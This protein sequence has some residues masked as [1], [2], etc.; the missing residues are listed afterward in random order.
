MAETNPQIKFHSEVSVINAIAL[1]LAILTG[2]LTENRIRFIPVRNFT[3]GDVCHIRLFKLR[4]YGGLTISAF[5]SGPSSPGS[6]VGRG[7]CVVFLGET[8]KSH[9]ASLHPGV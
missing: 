5:I 8:L 2:S 3:S 9:T 6:S 7:D 4:G 1:L